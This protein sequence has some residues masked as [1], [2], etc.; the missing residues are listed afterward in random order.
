MIEAKIVFSLISVLFFSSLFKVRYNNQLRLIEKITL[1][2]LFLVSILLI[3][4]PTLLDQIAFP[5]K[6]ERGRDLLFYIYMVFSSWGLIRS[7]IR[8]NSLSS[9]LNKLTS[10]IAINSPIKSFDN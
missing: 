3:L 7:H 5:L 6:I 8:I 10:Q 4:K 1:I 2:V 9:R